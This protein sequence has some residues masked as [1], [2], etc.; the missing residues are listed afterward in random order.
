M[1]ALSRRAACSARFWLR[2]QLRQFFTANV[3]P[4]CLNS[5]SSRGRSRGPYSFFFDPEV[6]LS[7]IGRMRI[8]GPRQTD[9]VKKSDKARK[10]SGASGEFKSFLDAETSGAAETAS[11]PMVADVGALLLAQASEDPAERKAKKRMRERAEDVLKALDG[12]HRGLVSGK[13]STAEMDSVGRAIAARREKINDSRLTEILD[14][15]EL[16]AQVEL[17]KM[18]MA[19]EKA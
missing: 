15:V 10:S 18:E 7:H 4:I 1:W 12:V 17:A 5:R 19:K 9:S 3:C 14:E 13:L 11:A 2:S 8:E 6:R 16:R